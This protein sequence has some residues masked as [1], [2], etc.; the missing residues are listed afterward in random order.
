MKNC[1]QSRDNN[2]MHKMPDLRAA[3]KRVIACSGAVTTDLTQLKTLA[4]ECFMDYLNGKPSSVIWFSLLAFAFFTAAPTSQDQENEMRALKQRLLER[5][6]H[7]R[8]MRF[9]IQMIRSPELQAELQIVPEQ[10]EEMMELVGEFQQSQIQFTI[11]NGDHQQKLNQLLKEN[12]A[13]EATALANEMFSDFDSS[14]L[15]LNKKV[16]ASIL[17]HQ[18]KRL[19]QIAMQQSRMSRTP[20]RDEFGLAL[21]IVTELDL[22]KKESGKITEKIAK[23]RSKLLNRI[24]ELRQEARNDVVQAFPQEHKDLI[25]DVYAKY[26]DPEKNSRLASEKKFEDWNNAR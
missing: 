5:E 21:A 3:L 15:S 24:E 1:S 25:K 14:M 7:V 23:I 11:K 2:I 18:L 13:A 8:Q 10:I 26:Y 6:S 17:P 20:F 9:L 4:R 12:N 16:E 22:P 19:Q